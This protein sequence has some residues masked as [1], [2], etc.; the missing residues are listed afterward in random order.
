MTALAFCKA[1]KFSLVSQTTSIRSIP[2]MAGISAKNIMVGL[3][4]A[5]LMAQSLKHFAIEWAATS[6]LEHQ[7]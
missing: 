5:P 2:G 7:I 4:E 1:L 3:I 6:T